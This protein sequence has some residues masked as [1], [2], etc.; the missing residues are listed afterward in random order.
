MSRLLEP[1]NYDAPELPALIQPEAQVIDVAPAGPSLQERLDALRRH[2]GKIAL[3]VVVC[4][5]VTAIYLERLPKLY[6]GVAIIRVDPSAPQNVVGQAQTE[7]PLD[8]ASLM[9]TEQQQVTTSA[10][11]IPVI[12]QLNLAQAPGFA[13]PP[14]KNGAQPFMVEGVPRALLNSVLKALTVARPPSTYLLQITFRARSPQLAAQAANAIA[15]SMIRHDYDTRSQALRSSSQ[16]LS[17]QVQQLRAQM[18]QSQQALTRY[19]QSNDILSPDDKFDVMS[20]RLSS[21]ASDL[22]KQGEQ[23]RQLEAELAMAKAGDI[24]AILASGRG[25][26]LR[27]LL[28]QLHTEQ[29]VFANIAAK[30]GTADAT[31]QEEQRRL[32]G[33]QDAVNVAVQHIAL[34]IQDEAAAQEAQTQLTQAAYD[35]QKQALQ[36]YNA[37]DA[38]YEL[39]KQQ[40]DSQA[41]LYDDMLGRIQEADVS[42]GYHSNDLRVVESALPNPKVAYPRI[43]LGLAVTFLVSLVL[44]I[45]AIFVVTSLDRTLTDPGSVLVGTGERLLAALPQE[46]NPEKLHSVWRPSDLVPVRRGYGY[47]GG[48]AYAEAIY[49]LRTSIFLGSEGP[50]TSVAVT[51]AQPRDGKTTT[52][53]SLAAASARNGL[54]TVLVDADLRRPEVHRLLRLSNRIGLGNYLQG[55]TS[56][57]D[58]ILATS[59]ANLFVIPAGPSVTNSTE[60]LSGRIGALVE[61]LKNRFKIVFVDCPPVLGFADSL[62][63]GPAVDTVLVVARAASTP[64]EYV[65]AAV[66]QLRHVRSNVGGVVLNGVSAQTNK[67]YSYYRKYSDYY[68]RDDNASGAAAGQAG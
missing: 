44:G 26:S 9:A 66:E 52:T 62:I 7:A 14:S 45:S 35:R 42:A 1:S 63:V 65:R 49:T 11:V 59:L 3:F 21:I 37:R 41:K 18:E 58:V 60:L 5:V 34:Q 64:R 12:N 20:Q 24:D 39:L 28:D 25:D 68:H 43:L 33:Y 10:V 23:Q 40:A 8:N 4:C 22:D 31:Y 32:Q 19:E 48:S 46:D 29:L 56:L 6:D 16:Y 51:S 30:Y 13:L 67:Y 54:L 15:D 61:D 53:V 36:D 50:L 38:Q 2:A 27:P 17:L 57:A 55:E 47:G